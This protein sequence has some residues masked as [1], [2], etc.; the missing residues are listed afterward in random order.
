[1]RARFAFVLLA[2]CAGGSRTSP[3]LDVH[4][5]SGDEASGDIDPAELGITA[6]S[7]PI[8]MLELGGVV[9]GEN[10]SRTV[11][12][13]NN[14][15]SSPIALALDNPVFVMG[16][17]CGDL[18]YGE[19]C[20]ISITF[21]PLV[22][23]RATGTL[24]ITST[25]GDVAI[26]LAGTGM[27]APSDAPDLAITFAGNGV[28]EVEVREEETSHV[29]ATCTA[30][31]AVSVDPGTK[32]EIRASTPSGFGGLAGACT[33]TEPGCRI[34]ADGPQ[35][36]TATFTQGSREWNLLLGG[37]P[38]IAAAYDSS[39]A[40]VVAQGNR[41]TK[42]SPTGTVVWSLP[43]CVD[44]VA[45]G[46]DD[47]IYIPGARLDANGAVLWG[48]TSSGCV[49]NWY[50]EAFRRPIAV[51][52]D[53]SVAIHSGSS[54]LRYTSD[55]VLAWSTTIVTDGYP[56]G[57]MIDGLGNVHAQAMNV[58]CTDDVLLAAADGAE[59]DRHRVSN[60]YRGMF[61][62]TP[63]R[64]L[65]VTSSGHGHAYLDGPGIAHD[66][67]T[68]AGGSVPNGVAMTGTGKIVW[69]Y[70]SEDTS[71]SPVWRFTNPFNETYGTEPLDVAGSL[72]GHYAVVGAYHGL[73]YRGAWIQSIAPGP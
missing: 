25:G 31:C 14:G 65:L 11:R 59:L 47:S 30:S 27:L 1:V 69:I 19:S 33:T 41:L 15:G 6:N 66:Y 56:S 63:D 17:A 53:G 58:D 24:I 3:Q 21:E 22:V 55:G 72:D 60:G 37:G 48:S 28:G 43:I 9:I 50:P 16:G 32:L 10:R 12:I 71:G 68:G 20:D 36:L 4:G 29:V 62:T 54:V 67:A 52:A 44:A 39:N 35:E 8:T 5:A 49:E 26:S 51:A 18:G 64:Q 13:R 45:T 46:P 42:V 70:Y 34:T 57:I 40:L 23:G 61:A 73:A 38:V 7:I 2:G